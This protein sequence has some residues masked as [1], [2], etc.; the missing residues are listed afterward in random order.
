MEWRPGR[1]RRR[2]SR[3]RRSV[4]L[5]G[6]DEGEGLRERRGRSEER[7]GRFGLRALQNFLVWRYLYYC[8]AF[9]LLLVIPFSLLF[10][11][12]FVHIFAFR[13]SPQIW[14]PV[15]YSFKS[16]VFTSWALLWQGQFFKIKLKIGKW[17][18]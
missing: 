9:V 12:F 1:G 11:F 5:G 2:S 8:R 4:G 7:R 18:K 6:F 10:F 16:R 13:V 15:L 14:W 3:R 17:K